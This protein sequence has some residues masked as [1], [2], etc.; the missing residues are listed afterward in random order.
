MLTCCNIF[1]YRHLYDLLTLA[2][3]CRS[4]SLPWKAK[5]LEISLLFFIFYK[6]LRDNFIGLIQSKKQKRGGVGSICAV[7][8]S[9]SIH[10][11][12]IHFL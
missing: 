12:L 9:S 11:I 7:G 1:Y 3:E 10:S 5:D 6:G 8:D 2:F 4:P